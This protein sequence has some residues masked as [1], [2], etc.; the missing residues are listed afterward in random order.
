[1]MEASGEMAFKFSHGSTVEGETDTHSLDGLASEPAAVVGDHH[2]DKR[3][4][5]IATSEAGYIIIIIIV[6]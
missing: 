3:S 4:L 1:M 2:H 5:D 6:V